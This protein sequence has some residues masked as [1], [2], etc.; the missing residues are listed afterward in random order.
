M[1]KKIDIFLLKQVQYLAKY[2]S[3]K[4]KVSMVFT[5]QVLAVGWF[6]VDA[7]RSSVS[8][9][10]GV[11]PWPV[12]M[13]NIITTGFVLVLLMT[14]IDNLPKIRDGHKKVFI[15]KILIFVR[16]MGFVL[17]LFDL[18]AMVFIGIKAPELLPF[19]V[20]TAASLSSLETFLM[21]LGCYFVSCEI[22]PPE[23][24]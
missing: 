21:V 16:K 9:L 15:L 24:V 6:M 3:Q 19:E 23:Q 10:F 14:A 11:V 5:I 1:L 13:L 2:F 22:A 8:V 20:I 17:V 18:G 7:S 12:T 4:W